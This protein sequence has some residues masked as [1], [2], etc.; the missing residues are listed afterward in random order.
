VPWSPRRDPV[1]AD[2]RLERYR[3]RAAR[4]RRGRDD[5]GLLLVLPEV[6]WEQTGGALWWRR[7]SAGRHAALLYVFLPESGLPFT[8]ELVVPDDL[9][10]ELDDW[11]A[12]RFRLAGETYAV[13]WLDEGESR[14]LAFE[15][16]GVGAGA[17]EDR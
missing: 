10:G 11:D 14:R 16:F 7:W 8:D 6:Y 13:Q 15:R 1:P 17:D 3:R 12:G 4:I 9:A 5:V 2:P